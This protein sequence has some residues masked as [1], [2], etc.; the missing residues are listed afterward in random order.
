MP[1]IAYTS[2]QFRGDTLRVITAAEAILEEYKGQGLTLTLRQLY[3]Q[4]VARGLMENTQK[5]YKRLG[6][7]VNNARLAAKI[8]WNMLVDRTRSVRALAHWNSVAEIMRACATQYR[9]DMW[10][11][12]NRYVE[13]W[14]EKDAL[15]GVITD[16]CNSLD[17]PFL[18]CRG[19]TSQSEMWEAGQRLAAQVCS[20]RGKTATI[21]HFGDH[22]PSGIDMSR[23]I[24]DRLRLFLDHET[25]RTHGRDA[26]DLLDFRRLALTW[27]QVQEYSPPP[28]PAKESDSRHAGY[29]ELYGDES[30][31]LDALPPDKLIALIREEIGALIEPGAWADSK[32]EQARGRSRLHDLADD[33]DQR[34]SDE[35]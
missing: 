28:N 35:D 14:I 12:Q 29:Q 21:L 8:D 34:G 31:E 22:D 20:R 25:R 15:V 33:E 19:Y 2:Q 9:V 30:W 23:D 3:Y 1:K 16:V 32:A 24:E 6:D 4:F 27:D 7:I 18:S 13:V 26:G 17:V 10:R 5:N 11:P